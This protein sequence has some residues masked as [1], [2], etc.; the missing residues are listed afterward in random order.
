M[1]QL[2]DD[3]ILSGLL[4][5]RA[6]PE[7][8]PHEAVY[9]T[10]YWYVRLCQAA[11]SPAVSGTLS[12]AFTGLPSRIRSR[13]MESLLELPAEVGLVSLRTLAPLIGRLRS[14]HRKLNLLSIE[15]LAAAIHLDA[16]TFLG[17]PSPPLQEA[18]T[19]E[20]RQAVVLNG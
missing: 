8:R 15:A 18:L 19:V 20:Q 13:A 6:A 5:G 12:G 9:T 11:F 10:G 4:Q 7:L 17:T 2:V 1:T 3:K 14:R 16:D